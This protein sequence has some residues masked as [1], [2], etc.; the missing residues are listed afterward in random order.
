MRI[1]ILIIILL[2]SINFAQ[3]DIEKDSLK[4]A[5]ISQNNLS[6]LRNELNYIFSD[7]NFTN[8][9]W[10]VS[11]QSLKTGETFYN[12]NADKLFKPASLIKLFTTS[13][14]LLLLGSDY[15]FKTSFYTD[16][17]IK[18]GVLHGNLVIVGG[19]DPTITTGHGDELKDDFIEWI[20]SL[21][22]MGIYSIKGNIIGDNN[23][24]EENKSGKGWLNEYD[25]NW[26]APPS[27]A[28]CLN[29][30][31]DEIILEPGDFKNL[32]KVSFNPHKVSYEVYNKIITEQE[33]SPSSI[34]ITRKGNNVIQLT[35]SIPDN[36]KNQ[37]IYIPVDNPTR[38]FINTF[39][40]TAIEEGMTITGFPLSSDEQNENYDL[41]NLLMLFEH[42]SKPLSKIVTEINKSS[43]NFYSEQLLKAIGYEL[44]GY[45]ST[46]NGITAM[47]ELLQK[48][49]IN[50]SNFVIVDGSGLSTFNLITPKQIINLLTYMYK[51]DEFDSFYNSLAIGGYDGTLSDRMK[52]TKAENNFRGKSGFLENVRGLA[53]YVKTTD[54]EPVALTLIV[55]NFLVPSQLAN[56][57]QDK[58]CNRLANFN[59]K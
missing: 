7:P 15:Q 59:R 25:S 58:V 54:G 38:F 55:N 30:N 56:Y 19:G 48:M 3:T 24:F 13:T 51:S 6:E 37:I 20:D 26:F 47:K 31:S 35:G 12:I 50:P 2:V 53:G 23:F 33:N 10:G 22:R 4:Q 32:V 42:K 46:E 49:G 17:K 28:F 45:G 57:V 9:F 16:G 52:K 41:S 34:S 40:E 1:S 14:G 36:D 39:Y 44:Y 5:N 43:N 29:N 11:I 18:D 27:G 21:N 8:A